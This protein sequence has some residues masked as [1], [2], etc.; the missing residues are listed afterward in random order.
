MQDK[1]DD[2]SL[3]II[4]KVVLFFILFSIKCLKFVKKDKK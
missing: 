3:K 4:F 2:S 1:W